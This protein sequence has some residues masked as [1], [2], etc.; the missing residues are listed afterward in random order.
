MG[1]KRSTT[2]EA[3][4]NMVFSY[5]AMGYTQPLYSP[6]PA[7][8]AGLS[9]AVLREGIARFALWERLY[10][11]PVYLVSWAIGGAV[12]YYIGKLLCS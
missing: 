5:F 1:N 11:I 10:P 12:G 4:E 7:L 8:Y 3:K 9:R 6:R 2:F